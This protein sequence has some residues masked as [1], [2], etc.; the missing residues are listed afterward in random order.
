MKKYFWLCILRRSPYFVGPTKAGLVLVIA[1]LTLIAGH[2][3]TN[4]SGGGSS[5]ENKDT[6]AYIK[7]ETIGGKLDYNKVLANEKAPFFLYEGVA[8]NKKDF[9]IFLW[10]KKLKTMGISSSKNAAELWEEINNKYLT[11]PERKAL[12]AGFDSKAK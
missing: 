2:A 5:K 11:E 9:A 7:K 8:Y 4:A 3:Q 12:I 6:V 1:T 10:G